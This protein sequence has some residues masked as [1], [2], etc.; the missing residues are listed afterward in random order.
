MRAR[1][2]FTVS[3]ERFAARSSAPG[4]IAARSSPQTTT[5]RIT[6][7]FIDAQS[8]LRRFETV[9]NDDIIAAPRTAN[10][11]LAVSVG[12]KRLTGSRINKLCALNGLCG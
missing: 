10:A 11:S 6:R 5:R 7:I 1:Q 8:S 9:K 4:V 2:I 12:R 3:G